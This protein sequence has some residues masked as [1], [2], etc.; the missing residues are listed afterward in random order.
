M[1]KIARTLLYSV[2]N[3][4]LSELSNSYCNELFQY[5]K[6]FPQVHIKIE[7]DLKNIKQQYVDI[8]AVIVDKAPKSMIVITLFAANEQ[9]MRAYSKVNSDIPRLQ[10]IWFSD[11]LNSIEED[12]K[13]EFN[14][15]TVTIWCVLAFV[16]IV[17]MFK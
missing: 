16:F 9:L 15:G 7:C 3:Y 2:L 14:R 8:C 12:S 11:I 1:D 5:S 10:A 17:Y 6:Q 4:E 13:F